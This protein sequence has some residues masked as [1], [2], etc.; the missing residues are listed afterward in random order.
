MSQNFFNFNMKQHK[1]FWQ[2]YSL[3]T[4]PP[5]ILYILQINSPTIRFWT[6]RNRNW[7]WWWWWLKTIKRIERLSVHFKSITF[8]SVV[9]A[10]E[11]SDKDLIEVDAAM[12]LPSPH[13]FLSPSVLPTPFD[14]VGVLLRDCTWLWGEGFFSFL[15]GSSITVGPPGSFGG[16]LED[17]VQ[18][19]IL[20][21]GWELT[22]FLAIG[23]PKPPSMDWIL[24]SCAGSSFWKRNVVFR[25]HYKCLTSSHI[26]Q[27]ACCDLVSYLCDLWGGERPIQVGPLYL[28]RWHAV[29]P[30]VQRPLLGGLP[31]CVLLGFREPLINK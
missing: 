23:R 25:V 8:E 20:A 3:S 4:S 17:D 21:C 19:E 13:C 22:P 1:E 28:F 12:A 7:W 14:G 6:Y 18:L 29:L 24:R 10:E 27:Q 5:P 15:K 2:H 26:W 31:S 30:R 16:P 11:E 9:S